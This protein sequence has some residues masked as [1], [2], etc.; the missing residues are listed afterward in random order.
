M[1][2][3]VPVDISFPN[4]ILSSELNRQ[5]R[6]QDRVLAELSSIGEPLPDEGLS[7]GSQVSR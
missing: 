1:H 5:A 4:W 7:G 2:Q 6:F 3:C